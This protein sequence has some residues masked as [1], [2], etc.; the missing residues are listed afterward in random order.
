MDIS[1]PDK[2]LAAVCGLFCPSC[3]MF[4]ASNEDPERLK[5]IAARQNQSMEDLRCEGCRAEKRTSYCQTCNMTVCAAEK[6]IDFCGECSEYPCAEIKEFQSIRPHRL[7]LWQSHERIKEVGFEQWYQEM[8]KHYSCSNCNTIN[9]AYDKVCRKCGNS[10]SNE[11]NDQNSQDI[12][13]RLVKK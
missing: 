9:S 8:I 13:Q 11:Y 6:G 10:P 4:I 3:T 7:E 2:K 12:Q 1:N 5:N